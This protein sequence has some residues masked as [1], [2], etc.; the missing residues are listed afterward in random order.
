MNYDEA[1]SQIQ[2]GD[3]VLV[4]GKTGFLTP[5]TQFFTRSAYTHAG[6]AFW[7]DGVLWMFEING[8]HNHAIPLSQLSGESFDVYQRPE[9]LSAEAVLAA[10][11]SNLREK[12]DYGFLALPVVGLLNYFGIKLFVHW[13]KILECAGICV[14]AYEDAG[15]PEQTY[16]L[17]PADLARMLTL[18]LSVS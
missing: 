7:M 6:L 4:K 2:T 5:F 14:K 18:R 11:F 15:W 3:G 13:R 16:I 12:I 8:G 17:S 10:I 1:R 9:G